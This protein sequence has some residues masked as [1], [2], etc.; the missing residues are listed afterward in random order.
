MTQEPQSQLQVYQGYCPVERS[1]G[2]QG[3]IGSLC[4]LVSNAGTISSLMSHLCTRDYW[5]G[6]RPEPDQP[7][8]YSL[9]QYILL[10]KGYQEWHKAMGIQEDPIYLN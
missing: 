9:Q 10:Q 8:Q 2:K 7:C 4:E 6:I 1:T 5:Q 3:Q